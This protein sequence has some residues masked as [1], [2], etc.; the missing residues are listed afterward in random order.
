MS[1]FGA[2]TLHRVRDSHWFTEMRLIVWNVV[3]IKQ[4]LRS[5]N[6]KRLI[7]LSNR[8]VLIPLIRTHLFVIFG[9][10]LGVWQKIAPIHILSFDIKCAGRKNT[11]PE[12]EKDRV[13]Q[14]ANMVI[15][16][17]EK[18][19]FIRNVFTLDTCASITGSD[20]IPCKTEKDLLEVSF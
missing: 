2:E 14:I 17:G 18:V 13:I 5:W 16:Q 20:V 15:R 10:I 1:K 6:V 8:Q 7:I 4:N 3:L 11:F 9:N 12:P 19:A